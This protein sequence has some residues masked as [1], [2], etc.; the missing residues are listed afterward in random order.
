MSVDP[1]PACTRG[2]PA[3]RVS[4]WDSGGVRSGDGWNRG[5]AHPF[6]ATFPAD[7][8]G[9]NWAC[10]CPACGTSFVTTFG[11]DADAAIPAAV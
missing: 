9:V 6:S 11:T 4:P 10:R 5:Y 2:S 8:R 1:K 3:P 7:A